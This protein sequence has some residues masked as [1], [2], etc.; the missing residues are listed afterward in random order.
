MNN[1]FHSL[2]QSGRACR[3]AYKESPKYHSLQALEPENLYSDHRQ[4]KIQRNLFITTFSLIDLM[5]RSEKI[6]KIWTRIH[7]NGACSLSLSLLLQIIRI[8]VLFFRFMFLL[9]CLILKLT[10]YQFDIVTENYIIYQFTPFHDLGIKLMYDTIH[11][12][13]TVLMFN[14]LFCYGYFVLVDDVMLVVVGG[15]NSAVCNSNMCGLLLICY[16]IVS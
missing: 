4:R 5:I 7:R 8:R 11:S 1:N 16:S 13:T 10:Y 12:T 6:I 2:V 9:W 3:Q 14:S 15:V